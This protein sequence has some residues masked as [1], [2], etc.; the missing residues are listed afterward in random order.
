VPELYTRLANATLEYVDGKL[1]VADWLVALIQGGGG[2][3]G[4]SGVEVADDGAF[5]ASRPRINFTGGAAVTDNPGANRVDIAISASGGDIE[6]VTAGTGLTGG[7]TSGTVAL[8]VAYGTTGGTST[9]GNDGRLPTTDQKA[10]LVG[11]DGTPS[12]A[13]PYVTDSDPRLSGGGGSSPVVWSG[14]TNNTPIVCGTIGLG[15]ARVPTF[16]D[17]PIAAAGRY[18]LEITG[19]GSTDNQGST[20]D[21]FNPMLTLTG[22]GT[23]A[24]SGMTG[25]MAAGN[26]GTLR[27]NNAPASFGLFQIYQ[28]SWYDLIVNIS[29]TVAAPGNLDLHFTRDGSSGVDANAYTRNMSA[30]LTYLGA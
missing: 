14:F 8:A 21:T 27:W 2:G 26:G 16:T 15:G 23:G 19:Q 20:G 11:T 1:K 24:G 28:P 10:A 22:T 4:I 5:V 29:F 18:L 25:V 6:G 12:G 9:Q 7:G 3:G 17:L 13:N 30:K